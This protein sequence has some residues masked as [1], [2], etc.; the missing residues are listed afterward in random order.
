[1]LVLWQ[2]RVL[3]NAHGMLKIC[4]HAWITAVAETSTGMECWRWQ[5]Q[6]IL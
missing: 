1:M 4:S 3:S 6:A 5:A 2:G